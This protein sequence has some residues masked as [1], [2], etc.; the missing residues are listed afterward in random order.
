MKDEALALMFVDCFPNTLDTT[1]N[2]THNTKT[3][4]Y[5]TFIITGDIPAMWLRDSSGQVQVYLPYASKDAQLKNMIKGLIARQMKQIKIDAYANAF[6]NA[7]TGSP[8]DS[9][10]RHPKMSP[11]LWEGKYELDSLAW[12]M[13]LSSKYIE[14][15]H[16]YTICTNEWFSSIQKIVDVIVYQQKSTEDTS[17]KD[18]LYYSFGRETTSQIDTLV[19]YHGVPGRTCGLSKGYFRPSDDAHRLPFQVASNA[20]VASS[21]EKIAKIVNNKEKECYNTKLGSQVS[22]LAL[23]IKSGVE[24]YGTNNH[25]L[26]GEIYAYEVD[27]YGSSYLM[28]DATVP[29]LISLPYF[30]YIQTSKQKEIY[31]HTR[32]FTLSS[33]NAYYFNGTAGDGIGSPHTDFNQIW[34]MG[35]LMRALTSNDDAEIEHCLEILK[36]STADLWFMHESFDKNNPKQFT[37]SWF[38]WANSLF[39][40]LILK[41]HSERPHLIYK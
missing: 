40:E 3:D 38:A 20:M 1:V 34:H 39:G 37:R 21:L 22:N 9:D 28:D 32:K 7:P 16:D 27:G 12:V 31:E 26:Y 10:E 6:N 15:T 2:F 17:N 8:H 13:W 23:L 33:Y 36:S 35:I 30:E 24:N 11:M 14:H 5:D 29:N 18:D 25:R 19:N 41:L 4:E